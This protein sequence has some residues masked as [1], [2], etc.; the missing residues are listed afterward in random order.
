ML[1]EREAAKY[2]FLKE[3]LNLLAGLD[4]QLDE[5]AGPAYSK[6]IDRAKER[7]IEAIL[8][9][10]SSSRFVDP[11]T[12]M[13]SYPIAVM[14]VTLVAEQFLNRRFSL[15]E[16]VRAYSLLQKEDEDR[17][18]DIALNE[19]L[20]QPLGILLFFDLRAGGIEVPVLTLEDL[21]I[22]KKVLR[23]CLCIDIDTAFPGL[24]YKLGA[25][26]GGHMHDIECAPGGLGPGD[27]SLNSLVFDDIGPGE[28]M[29]VGSD[30]VFLGMVSCNQHVK[31]KSAFGVHSYYSA[32]I[33][34]FL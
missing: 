7:V 15:S 10:E 9:G 17:I 12:E 18:L 29:S 5:L 1:A 32:H 28:N 33:G 34:G 4:L 19:P 14:Y 26:A 6:V 2:P 24:L 20:P 11:Q 16:A 23:A 21:V 22:Q 25:F 31:N 27:G 13:L 30:L 3:G 8:A